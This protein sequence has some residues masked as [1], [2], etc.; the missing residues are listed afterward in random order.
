MREERGYKQV[1]ALLLQSWDTTVV[2]AST[3]RGA[4]LS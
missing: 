2:G 1:G 3:G 4:Y